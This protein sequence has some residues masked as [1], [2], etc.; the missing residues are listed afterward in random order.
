MDEFLKWIDES[1][2]KNLPL[3]QQIEIS[4][5]IVRKD[6]TFLEMC[7]IIDVTQ[8]ELQKKALQRKKT[9]KPSSESDEGRT[10]E[11]I[12]SL[13]GISRDTYHKIVNIKEA[14]KA[15]PEKFSDIPERIE[16]G[17]S[18]EY[19]NKMINTKIKRRQ[20]GCEPTDLPWQVPRPCGAAHVLPW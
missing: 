4:E 2:L 17:M 6:F 18:I 3:E 19:A 13:L 16:K 9:G 7:A 12:S 20:P 10:D 11:K 14:I 5:N 15:D 8:A 1:I